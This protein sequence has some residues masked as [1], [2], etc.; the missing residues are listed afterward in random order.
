MTFQ[1]HF[2]EQAKQYAIHRPRYPKDIYNYL[3]SLVSSKQIAWDAG[4][5]SGQVAVALTDYFQHVIATDASSD[6]IENAF[7]HEQIDY[8]IEPAE[9]TSITSNS[10]DLV[11][12]GTAVHWFELD[13]FYQEVNRVCKRNAVVAVWVYNLPTIESNVDKILDRF[14]NKILKP[15]WPER[16]HYLFEQYRTLPFPF[17]EILPPKFTMETE[18]NLDDLVG[19]LSSW[20]AIP[21][22]LK[23]EGIHPLNK[24]MED[25]QRSW[26]DSSQ[27]KWV[28]WPLFFRIGRITKQ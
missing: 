27:K 19:F 7:Q 15:Y 2:S 23:A 21:I 22:Y 17:E 11:T 28:K 12:V 20:S 13:A 16:L 25:L 26:V 8:R 5:G 6:Q 9:Q 24:I 10:V 3:A 14:T 18:W 4:T 1:D